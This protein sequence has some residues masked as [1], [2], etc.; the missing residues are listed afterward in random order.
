M[1]AEIYLAS[2]VILCPCDIQLSLM[3]SLPLAHVAALPA[4]QYLSA[5]VAVGYIEILL[6]HNDCPSCR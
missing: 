4:L 2:V 3:C 5:I 6:F 1:D